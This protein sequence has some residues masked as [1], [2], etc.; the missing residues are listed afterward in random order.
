MS[1]DLTITAGF[2][3][4]VP[5][6]SSDLTSLYARAREFLCEKGFWHYLLTAG[7]LGRLARFLPSKW[8]NRLG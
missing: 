1:L 2:E 3:S 5:T 6:E 8:P 4:I 7:S